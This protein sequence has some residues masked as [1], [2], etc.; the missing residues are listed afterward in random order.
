LSTRNW[1]KNKWF[2][3]KKPKILKNPKWTKRIIKSMKNK[4]MKKRAIRMKKRTTRVNKTLKRK[5]K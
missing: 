1:K 5:N 3:S 2:L 4:R